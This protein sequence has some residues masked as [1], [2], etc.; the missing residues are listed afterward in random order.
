M[1]SDTLGHAFGTR[2][3]RLVFCL[4]ALV[5][6]SEALAGGLFSRSFAAGDFPNSVTVADLDGDSVPDLVTANSESDDVSVLRGRGDGSFR[7]AVSFA[8][9]NS[10]FSVAVADLDGDSIPD[11][12]TANRDSDDV[13]VLLGNGDA[14]FRAAVSYAVIDYPHSVAVADLDGD[15]VPD[16]VTAD[17]SSNGV[18]VLFGNGDGTFRAPVS[19]AAGFGPRAVAVA[20]L[21]G[22]SVPDL[23]TANIWGNEVGVLLGNGDG[24]FQAPI[25][26]VTGQWP[27]AVAVADLD[28]DSVPDLVTANN[29]TDDLSVLLGNGD[30]SFQAA[31]SFAAGD[32]ANAIAVAD[33][34]GDSVPDLVS[35]NST[36]NDVSVL[37][38]NG[39]GSFQAAVSFVAGDNAKSVAVADFD[40]DSVPDLVTANSY[41]NDVS[42]L[43]GNGD[44]RFQAAVVLAAGF[45][46]QSAAAADLDGDSVPD[47]VVANGGG[48]DVSVLLGN[49]A[50]RFQAAVSYP[51]G[52]SPFFV[53][54]ADL[55]GDTLLDL[56]TANRDGNNANVLLGN[57][58]GTFQDPVAFAV[59][60]WPY[61][62]AVADFDDDSVP[63]L[64]TANFSTDDLTVLLGN[65]DGSFQ[66]GVSFAAGNG[67]F[68][69][70]VADLDGDS[71]LDLVSANSTSDD[72]SVLLG[73][74]DGSFQAAVS[75]AAGIGPH[76]VA[77]ADLD[78]DSVPDLV[79]A[80]VNGDEV[81]LLLGNGDGSFQAAVSF[82]TGAGPFAVAVAD[83]DAD[84]LLDVVTASALRDVSVL[85]GNGDATFRA[86][87][88]SLAGDGPRSIAVADL[89]GDTA[90]DLVTANAHGGVTV[91]FNLCDPGDLDGD[92]ASNCFDNC[93]G[94]VNPGQE[95]ADG[96][97]L[98]D[99]CNNAEDSDGDEFS[100][101]LDTCSA[102]SNPGQEDTD[103]DGLGDACNDADDADGDEFSD[104]LDTCP[105]DFNPGQEDADGDGIGDLCN[106]WYDGDGDEFANAIDNCPIVF[107]P[108][109]EDTEDTLVIA[110][111]GFFDLIEPG[112]GIQVGSSNAE[113][114]G[115]PLTG[116][117]L[118][119]SCG[120]CG[121]ATFDDTVSVIGQGHEI[122]GYDAEIPRQIARNDDRLC[123]RVLSTGRTF[124]F[125]LLSFRGSDWEECA[126]ADGGASCAA[127]SGVTSYRRP[128]DGVGDVCDNCPSDPNPDQSDFDTDGLGDMCDDSDGDAFVDAADNCP[129]DFNPGQEDTEDTL[130]I[131][132]RGFFDAIEPGAGIQ[133]GSSFPGG[134]GGPLTGVGLQ[135]SCGTC[136]EATFEDAVS[137]IGQEREICGYDSEI[138][139]QIVQNDDRLCARVLST[140]RTFEFDM[141]SFRGS[142]RGAC[143]DADDGES[144]A[145]AGGATSYWR[146]GD[147]VGDVCDNCAND[148]NSDQADFD[149]DGFG[150]VCGDSDSDD[151]VDVADNCPADFNP[152]QED[153]EDSLVIAPRGFFDAVESGVGIQVGSSFPLGGGGPITGVGLQFSC[154]T[155]AEATFEDAVSVIGQEH[156][157]C[158]YESEIPRQIVQNDDHLCARVLSTGRVFEFDLLSFQGREECVDADGGASCA[159]ASGVTSYRRPGDGVGDVCDNCPSDLNSDQADFDTDGFGDVCEDSDGDAF[160]DAVDNCPADFNPGQED[161]EDTLVIA[162]RGS[163]DAVEPGAGIRVGSP[164]PYGGI[165]AL[166]G[167]GIQF[168]CG[169]CAE[170]TFADAVNIIGL[171][172]EIC[173]Y[174]SKIPRQIVQNDDRLCGLVLSTGRTFEF[175]LLSFRGGEECV[176]ADGGASC[177]SAGD[178]T[179]YLRTGD[180]VGDVCDNCANDSNPDQADFDTDGIGDVCDDS[181]GDD[182]VDAADNCP[183]DFNPGQGDS[184]DTLVI[185]PRNFFDAV[186][187][188]AGIQ[189]GSTNYSGGGGPLTGVGIQFSCGTCV[190][191]TFA[192]AV[193]VIGRENE[194]CGYGYEIPRRIVQN[195][196][197]LCAR[198]LS[199][200]RKFEFDMLS[201]RGS[202]WE[203]CADADDGASCAAAGSVT[204]YRRTGD[205]VGDACDNCPNNSNPDQADVDADEIGD[206][207]DPANCGDGAL[208]FSEQCD[209][210]NRDDGDG[211]SSYCEIEN[212]APE[213][214]E[215]SAR[216]DLLWSID[217]K[218]HSISIEGVTDPD[219]DP[220]E[221]TIDAIRRDETERAG[222]PAS[223][224]IGIGTGT[225]Q[226]RA[227]RRGDGDGRVYHIQFE[228]E[229]DR[230]GRC[231]STVQ[232]CVPHDQRRDADGCVDQGPLFDATRAE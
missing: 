119:F 107:N 185:A 37:L 62:L 200:G 1:V 189:V 125:D 122:C 99:A 20:D 15:S 142:D 22:D 47:L 27:S 148:S 60:G 92:G 222:G 73:N 115:G 134:G 188:G 30:G 225:A 68:F 10:P 24:S 147:S 223:S 100:D 41:R 43:L 198:V 153:T 138:P 126:D 70:A 83:L 28:G 155:C 180:R 64:V 159:A 194:I 217:Q 218:L 121:E 149:A 136:A 116:V 226:V 124:E 150:D 213:C 106:E 19:F 2:H 21:D 117:G 131:A 202:V 184:E 192:D 4:A 55:D 105:I 89:N 165:G 208:G 111:R 45:G 197:R 46:P 23:A 72:V 91:L 95:D 81:S 158:D 206:I 230:G 114:G 101:V 53:A 75:F 205:S 190:E 151:F 58:D 87:I 8:V 63:D 48:E 144:C 135:F 164:N 59:G 199:T 174:D 39:D 215:A 118:Q 216:P 179:S 181:D 56:A 74:G 34:D 141:L 156:E 11:L 18:S 98:G 104:A 31:V 132:P 79:V 130:V 191:A 152:G 9:G 38:G 143:D 120:T 128:G 140:G 14:S 168:S 76:S 203:E 129:A 182:L 170:A 66:S 204:S 186:E 166:L 224:A 108:E 113:G 6:A 13:S 196:D 85:L 57:G 33:F 139:R 7:P 207:C 82:V 172:Q 209:D 65:G 219:G 178:V 93:I 173:G 220:I 160:V 32:H 49:G 212:H 145:A 157:I 137:V 169:R 36:S 229:D 17:T 211:C 69:V 183:T 96:D 228:A 146:V 26:F 3:L 161:T 12:V 61:A 227:E 231:S 88:S 171:E 221:V 127:A 54:V 195:D 78:R 163:F 187:P 201:F 133:V 25:T 90:P 103:S 176:D 80:N 154:G 210:G 97:G 102:E 40:G 110:P 50:G 5:I 16:L 177:A 94:T 162:S 193:S 84:T 42:V 109:Q 167:V 29:R 35:A 71:V 52:D 112:V 86:A 175:D 67:P 232:V 214:S 44:G 77:V 123:A 51:A